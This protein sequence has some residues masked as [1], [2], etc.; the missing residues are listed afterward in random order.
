M[1]CLPRLMMSTV[2]KLCVSEPAFSSAL[3]CGLSR[4]TCMY[5]YVYM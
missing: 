2:C 5:V 3:T 4:Q 1:T